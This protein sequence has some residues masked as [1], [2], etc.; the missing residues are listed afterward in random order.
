LLDNDQQEPKDKEVA[1]DGNVS[2]PYIWQLGNQQVKADVAVLA[3]RHV[4]SDEAK[5][6]HRHAG[7]LFGPG[8]GV[9]QDVSIKDL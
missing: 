9:V 2:L 3:H 7:H 4:G 5:P 8:Q 1:Q 6:N